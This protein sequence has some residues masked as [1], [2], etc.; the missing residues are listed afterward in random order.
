[1][2]PDVIDLAHFYASHLGQVAQRIIRRRLRAAWPD[3]KGLRV[4]GVG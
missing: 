1:M 4:L 2:R 3:V